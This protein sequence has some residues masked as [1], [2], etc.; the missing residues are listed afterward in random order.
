MRKLLPILIVAV[1]IV[2]AFMLQYELFNFYNKDYK[3][4]S[5]IDELETAGSSIVEIDVS[6]NLFFYLED[7]ELENQSFFLTYEFENRLIVNSTQKI[8]D[9]D[10]VLNLK[11]TIRQLS[12]N[13][14]LYKSIIDLADSTPLIELS[15]DIDE[16]LLQNVQVDWSTEL[17]EQILVFE[18]IKPPTYPNTRFL[19]GLVLVGS[20]MLI[21][22]FVAVHNKEE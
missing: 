5:N 12:S 14:P 17:S 7:R 22:I 16:D 15:E 18:Q 10:E 2:A 8:S 11:G 1:S 20:S 3:K 13:D 19:L 21:A 4:I 6:S 9:E